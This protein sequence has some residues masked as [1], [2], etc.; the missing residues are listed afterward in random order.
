MDTT[1]TF[2]SGSASEV[3]EAFRALEG[4]EVELTVERSPRQVITSN[5]LDE[6]VIRYEDR[7]ETFQGLLWGVRLSACTVF[8]CIDTRQ[9]FVQGAH[10]IGS[11]QRYALRPADR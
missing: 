6:T 3:L 7:A 5:N 1:V 8:A 9:V 10:P 11:A 2:T 4:V